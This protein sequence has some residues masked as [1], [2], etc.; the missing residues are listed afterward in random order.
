MVGLEELRTIW[1][2]IMTR[3][4][5]NGDGGGGRSSN[6]V[7][8]LAKPVP[9]DKPAKPKVRPRVRPRPAG[10]ETTEPAV[11]LLALDLE[12]LRRFPPDKPITPDNISS[13]I[14]RDENEVQKRFFALLDMGLLRRPG[15]NPSRLVLS[16]KGKQLVRDSEG[17]DLKSE[18][19]TAAVKIIKAE[20]AVIDGFKMTIQ[21]VK[22]RRMSAHFTIGEKLNEVKAS[23]PRGL[24]LMW[25]SYN[26]AFSE[27]TA[28]RHMSFSEKFPKSSLTMDLLP[29]ME[30]EWQRLYGNKPKKPK[31]AEDDAGFDGS[32]VPSGE[33]EI[34]DADDTTAEDKEAESHDE[35]QEDGGKPKRKA[36]PRKGDTSVLSVD[37]PTESVNRWGQ[38]M[39]FAK[40]WF[41]VDSDS[42][43]TLCLVEDWMTR[44]GR[45]EANSK[46]ANGA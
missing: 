18:V 42:R 16:K 4:H 14:G 45:E 15:A 39:E 26:F 33:A 13:A 32:S 41:N 9:N 36:K 8:S 46:E 5:S 2:T 11:D 40:K 27:I 1:R 3:K 25:L 21:E 31:P 34:M 6:K 17:V 44:V 19:L 38:I 35:T 24:W 20:Q 22:L 28:E 23:L 10:A 7:A 29:E 12:I 43:A 30:A 37:V